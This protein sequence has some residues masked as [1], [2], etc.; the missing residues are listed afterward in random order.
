MSSS[1]S[2]RSSRH[3]SGK[4]FRRPGKP[5]QRPRRP[6]AAG[7]PGAR[8]PARHASR[9]D[10]S[11]DPASRRLQTVLADAGVGSRRHCEQL[12]TDGRVDVDGQVVTKLGTKV[13]P[14]QQQIRLDGITLSAQRRSYFAVHK[15][16]GVVST[17]SDPAGRPRVVDLL[18]PS[19]G[20]VYTVG[21]L[22]LSSEGLILV[23]N[24]GD[25]ADRLTHPRYGVAKTYQVLVAGQISPEELARL[26]RGVHLAEGFAKVEGARIK[27]A[28]KQSSL[29]EIVLREGRNREIRRL[30]A[31]AGHKVLRLKRIAIA[32]LRLADMPSGAYR[33]LRTDEVRALRRATEI[34][35]PAE[36]TA[37]EE[38]SDK[39]SRTTPTGRKQTGSGHQKPGRSGTRPATN[40]R[41]RFGAD[42]T[43]G[44]TGRRPAVAGKPRPQQS[45]F[46][47][48]VEP[49][50]PDDMFISG[51]SADGLAA[52]ATSMF[53]HDGEGAST[54][55]GK[56]RFGRGKFRPGPP[57]KLPSEMLRESEVA[58]SSESDT[59]PPVEEGAVDNRR[60]R[61]GKPRFERGKPRVGGRVKSKGKKPLVGENVEGT[62]S[63]MPRT[64]GRSGGAKRPGGQGKPRFERG[65]TRSGGRPKP[66][67]AKHAGSEK[68]GGQ[69]AANAN[70]GGRGR[71]S[72][73]AK[74]KPRG[75]RR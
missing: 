56:P 25:L 3:K 5:G 43:S 67:G 45:K 20:R 68:T 69:E 36:A 1:D 41:K 39:K 59:P 53:G 31:R 40:A 19:V 62:T 47:A 44:R 46:R 7:K 32:D 23:T 72:R 27:S 8:Q 60:D 33:M 17:N 58:G 28:H 9:Q 42:T 38:N 55:G 29:L 2:P 30:L 75:R 37:G 12:I 57:P 54:S 74:F 11:G 63:D 50:A 61:T 71:G 24:D 35:R 73:P 49:I 4:P 13:N 16:V 22:D 15:P 51:N 70:T 66:S 10:T 64:G 34:G 6:T 52:G 18:P 14:Q 26:Q 21:R 65:K 48:R